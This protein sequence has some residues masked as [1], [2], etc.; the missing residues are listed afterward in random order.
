MEEKC[1]IH[2]EEIISLICRERKCNNQKL[3]TKCLPQHKK[4]EIEDI[5]DYWKGK[6]NNMDFSALDKEVENKIRGGVKSSQE[7][8]SMAQMCEDIKRHI[9]DWGRQLEVQVNS[10][11]NT[12]VK[13]M[14]KM[15]T[16]YEGIIL[17]A[18]RRKQCNLSRLVTEG[19]ERKIQVGEMREHIS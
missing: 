15:I 12:E 8:K 9:L 11:I 19:K 13:S 16:N 1:G 14:T 2:V 7:G 10:N 18:L 5:D 3:C 4:H 6:I 17:S